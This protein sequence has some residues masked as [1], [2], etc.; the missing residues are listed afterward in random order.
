MSKKKKKF[1]GKVT[2]DANT[3]WPTDKKLMKRLKKVSKKVKRTV[4]IRSGY[5]SYADQ[6]VLYRRY[7]NGT[8]NLAAPPGRSNHNSG[9]AADC[10]IISS[11][12]SY[13]SIGYN[14]KA[15]K[16]MRKYRLCLPVPGEKW[17]V[18]RGNT[19]RS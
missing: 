4:H 6:A 11:T 2:K 19:W 3:R 12:G 8:G 17:H 14:A 1:K 7:L 10:G 18:E 9:R 16:Y 13:S 15:R 5:R